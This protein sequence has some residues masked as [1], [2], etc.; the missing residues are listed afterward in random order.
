MSSSKGATIPY[1]WKS[2]DWPK[3]VRDFPPPPFFQ[4]VSGR[5][6]IDE[7]RAFQNSLFMQRIAEGWTAPFYQKLWGNAGVEPGDIR[8]LDD[9]SKL[10]SFTSD[11]LKQA[12]ADHPPYGTHIPAGAGALGTTPLKVQTSGGTT[13]VPRITLFDPMA[14]EVQAIQAARAMYAQG[15]RPGDR[16]QILFTTSLA[17]AGWCIHHGIHGWLGAVSVTSGSGVVTPSERQ[18]ELAAVLGTNV[19]YGTAE[20]LGRLAEVA[21]K[22]GFDLRSLPTKFLTGIL[23]VDTDG[24]RRERLEDAW[25]APYYDTWGSHEVGPVAFECSHKDGKHI[26][27]DTAYI[28]ITDVENGRVLG[29]GEEGNVVATSLA[30]SVPL[31]IRYNLRDRLKMSARSRCACG[32]TTQKLSLFL[33]R[34]DEM[35]KLRGTNVYPM[36]CISVIALEPRLTDDYICVAYHEGE[37]LGRRDEMVVRIERKSPDID[38][39]LLISDMEA[40]F[41]RDLGVKVGVQV[42]EA[43]ELTPQT[44][45]GGEGKARR[46]L[47]LRKTGGKP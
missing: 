22:T 28:E 45:V 12:S 40:N 17:N 31:F 39:A 34:S 11:D 1:Y 21:Q 37:G 36:A 25:G 7:L 46:L 24:T 9:I 47:D 10:P 26:S 16:V 4:D 33:G 15:A 20:Y 38:K 41:K 2:V 8:S 44:K 3:L 13:G 14:G 6:S 27:E 32:L 42:F 5:K 19:W 35:V 29:N 43:G 18:L 23:G 30:R